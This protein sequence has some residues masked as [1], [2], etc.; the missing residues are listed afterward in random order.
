[1]GG[2]KRRR[3]GGKAGRRVARWCMRRVTLASAAVLLTAYPPSRLSAQV[4]YPPD[5]SPYR[6]VKRGR[7]LIVGA[8]YLTGGRGVVDVGPSNGRMASARFELPVGKPLA[9][10]VGAAYGRMSRFVADP[11]KD[12]AAHISGPINT[13]VAILEGGIHLFLSGLKTW[14]ALAPYLG[15]SGGG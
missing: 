3:V 5:H 8:G 12:S 7:A 14:H 4:G 11:T 2:R 6:D 13:D 15:V 10:F 1:M 9:F